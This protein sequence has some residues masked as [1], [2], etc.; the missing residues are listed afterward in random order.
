MEL[1]QLAKA[2]PAFREAA[3]VSRNAFGS[4]PSPRGG[5]VGGMTE[6]PDKPTATVAIASVHQ[7]R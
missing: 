4:F 6:S 7:R 5:W 2:T 3:A 1:R